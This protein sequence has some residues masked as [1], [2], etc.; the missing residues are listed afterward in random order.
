MAQESVLYPEGPLLIVDKGMR[1]KAHDS[2]Y[3]S[4]P[5]A[6]SS[7]DVKVSVLGAESATD[8]LGHLKASGKERKPAQV[9]NFRFVTSDDEPKR[10]RKRPGRPPRTILGDA[11]GQAQQLTEASS[12]PRGVLTQ[13]PAQASSV[14]TG[15]L[16]LI[17]AP[18]GSASPF[19]GLH[20]NANSPLLEILPYYSDMTYFFYPLQGYLPLK[21]DPVT[22][23]YLPAAL[24]DAC[25]LSSIVT[26]AAVR[27]EKLLGWQVPEGTDFLQG[28]I[29][30]L[31]GR[32]SSGNIT[33]AVLM[34]VTCFL[35]REHAAGR[36]DKWQTHTNG[37]IKM[38]EIR[39]GMKSVDPG[40]HQKIY[41]ALMSPAIDYLS[42]PR[43]PRPQRTTPS[44]YSTVF[45]A[46]GNV[47]SLPI[48]TEHNV[49]MSL[50]EAPATLL[51]LQMSLDPD[52]FDSLVRLQQLADAINRAIEISAP[53]DPFSLDQDIM[54]VQYD[55][56]SLDDTVLSRLDTA[57]KMA[58]L[59]FTRMLTHEQPFEILG[60]QTLPI[61]M[62]AVLDT[63]EIDWENSD[64]KFWCCFMGALA[65]QDTNKR[66]ASLHHLRSCSISL[67]VVDWENARFLLQRVAW[68]SPAF[69]QNGFD[70]WQLLDSVP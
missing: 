41:R 9:R 56:L 14:S 55:L 60:A 70:L 42:K 15:D 69:D 21:F 12:S 17:S 47:S 1:K 33:D 50:T 67:G 22:T 40:F 23:L 24:R 63:I 20:D 8:G 66:E 39:G 2:P 46:E 10:S 68:V 53:I 35:L 36:I 26:S 5:F 44:L 61:A 7:S 3:E 59:I 58:A 54:T 27:C 6:V 18:P 11:A 62:L 31:R 43:W 19:Y 4:Q 30:E 64:L 48:L 34:A 52:L 37:L 49:D 32:V 45:L 65:A 29:Q 13:S 51:H 28:A 38:L 16:P 25:M 57:C